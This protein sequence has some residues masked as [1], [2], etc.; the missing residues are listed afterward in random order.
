M[1]NRE[2]FWEGEVREE[3]GRCLRRRRVLWADY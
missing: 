1:G 3:G 2:G